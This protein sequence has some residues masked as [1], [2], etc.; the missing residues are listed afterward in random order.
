MYG[1]MILDPIEPEPFQY[2]RDYVVILS[3][4]SHESAEEM[5]DS[6]KKFSGYYN[7]QKRDAQ[8]FLSDASRRGF[9]PTLRNYVMWDEMRMDPTD[10][11]DVTGSTL[12]LPHE[13]ASTNRTIGPGCFG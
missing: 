9:W 1:T 13:R 2:D 10:F 4:W 3:E 6:L 12:H 5:L 8:E 7:Y 11:A